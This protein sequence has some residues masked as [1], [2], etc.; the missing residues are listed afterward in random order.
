MGRRGRGAGS[1]EQGGEEKK[2]G[3]RGQVAGGED[4]N[5]LMTND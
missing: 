3:S 4:G 1:R 5:F 2:Q